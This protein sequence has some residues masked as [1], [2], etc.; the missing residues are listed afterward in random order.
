V[1]SDDGGQWRQAFGARIR[2]LRTER[3]LSQEALALAA[4]MSTPYLSDVE[5]GKRS[6]GLDMI[7][8]LAVALDL[9]LSEL[10]AGVS[11]GEQSRTD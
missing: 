5:R 4:G 1:V 10:F 3:G 2:E 11:V 7:V 9:S 8:A 6:P